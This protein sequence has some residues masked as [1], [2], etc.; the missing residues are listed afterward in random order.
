MACAVN[1]KATS[2]TN[3][4]K[5]SISTSSCSAACWISTWFWISC[6]QSDRSSSIISI[7]YLH[8][9]MRPCHSWLSL[10]HIVHD[11]RLLWLKRFCCHQTS[12]SRRRRLVLSSRL[13]I[14]LTADPKYYCLTKEVTCL[15]LGFLHRPKYKATS[16]PLPL[17]P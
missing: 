8:H 7:D 13:S 9:R 17:S 5:M 1:C 15:A 6:I 3:P 11:Y 16:L 10:H 14:Q 4:L 12:E 2:K